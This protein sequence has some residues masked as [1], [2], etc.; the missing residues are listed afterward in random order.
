MGPETL[1]CLSHTEFLNCKNKFV[2]YKL[3]SQAA[4]V[5]TVNCIVTT[6]RIR[7]FY[8]YMYEI[9]KASYIV[10]FLPFNGY[11]IHKYIGSK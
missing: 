10:C 4:G 11:G 9:A 5:Q 6:A 1:G 2:K 8:V 7:Q 3:Y